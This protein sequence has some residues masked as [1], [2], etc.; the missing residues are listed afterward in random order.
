MWDGVVGRAPNSNATDLSSRPVRREL[1]P[2]AFSEG[3]K[4]PRRMFPQIEFFEMGVHRRSSLVTRISTA[5]IESR[6]AVHCRS[7]SRNADHAMSSCWIFSLSGRRGEVGLCT[8]VY[9]LSDPTRCVEGVPPLCNPRHRVV[10]PI[11]ARGAGE[12]IA[13]NKTRLVLSQLLSTAH[14]TPKI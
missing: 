14:E 7:I 4:P 5:N 8:L 1:F 9:L 2:S 6:D 10:C 12:R 13:R 3:E 11:G